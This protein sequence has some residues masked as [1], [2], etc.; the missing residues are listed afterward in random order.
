MEQWE[1][2]VEKKSIE[3]IHWV[4]NNL[5]N[6]QKIYLQYCLGAEEPA[7]RNYGLLR[8]FLY[9]NV[10]YH[11][12]V[13]ELVLRECVNHLK[14]DPKSI[15]VVY[16]VGAGH[17]GWARIL[18]RMFPD[19]RVVLID[20]NT[21]LYNEGVGFQV[22]NKNIFDCLKE[23][24][25]EYGPD[26]LYFM[27]EFLHCKIDNKR[28]LTSEAMRQSQICINELDFNFYNEPIHHRLQKTGGGL[29]DPGKLRSEQ[30]DAFLFRK[31]WLANYQSSF[32]YYLWL[33]ILKNS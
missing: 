4:A 9:E 23:D 26:V 29:I 2:E 13:C 33:L 21:V 27:S 12:D 10:L 19:A 20:K 1:T 22:V 16:D 25:L 3:S 7:K 28:V 11:A 32:E 31:S 8:R 30:T 15:R 24:Y 18:K 14:L 17:D 5:D 6:I